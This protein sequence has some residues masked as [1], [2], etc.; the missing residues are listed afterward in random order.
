M[1]ERANV[2]SDAVG[3]TPQ[4]QVKDPKDLKA[5]DFTWDPAQGGAS[6]PGY[7]VMATPDGYLLFDAAGHKVAQYDN[8]TG[9]W[10]TGNYGEPLVNADDKVGFKP[11]PSWTDQPAA[12]TGRAEKPPEPTSAPR[13][14]ASDPEFD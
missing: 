2:V 1:G 9:H 3:G 11:D 10:T 6:A 4:T 5:S 13:P 7:D 8:S 14:D 12:K